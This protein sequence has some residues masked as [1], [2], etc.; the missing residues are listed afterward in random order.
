VGLGHLVADWGWLLALVVGA[1]VWFV[2]RWLATPAGR[3]WRDTWLLRL[4]VFGE[5]VRKYE[6]TR[7][8]RSL[9]TLLGNGVPIVTAVGIANDTMDNHELRAAMAA[10]APTIKQ[11]GRLADALEDAGLF[12][13]LALNMVRLGEETGRLDAML[14]ELARVHDGEVQSGVKRALTLVEPLLILVLGAVIAAIIV[15]I[16]LGILSVNELAV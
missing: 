15:S 11:G 12:T 7:F 3:L 13:P 14:L 16:L 9:G 6:I 5:V 10:V 8:A 2:R 4:P 1:A